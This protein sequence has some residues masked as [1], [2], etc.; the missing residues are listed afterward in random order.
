MEEEDRSD[1]SVAVE[2]DLN[3]LANDGKK[4]L[5]IEEE[6]EE[7][8]QNYNHLPPN[9]DAI[10]MKRSASVQ[11][12]TRAIRSVTPDS[13]RSTPPPR[14]LPRNEDDM[15]VKT[16]LL[17][18][19]NRLDPV[20]ARKFSYRSGV[21]EIRFELERV[22]GGIYTTQAI[23]KCR[24]ITFFAAKG[25]ETI[26]QKYNPYLNLTG[27]SESLLVDLVSG[28]FDEVFLELYNKYGNAVDPPPEIKL[29]FMVASSAVMF[30]YVN[31]LTGNL[32][33]S[34][35]TK[36]T[37]EHTDPEV[38]IDDIVEAIKRKKSGKIQEEEVVIEEVI[39]EEEEEVEVVKPTPPKKRQPRKAKAPRKEIED[40]QS[41]TLDL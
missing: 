19:L 28:N 23:N 8:H 27:W 31:T 17:F 30:H 22:K 13:H 18:E 3:L 41:L 33:P 7:D 1:H 10:S 6:D 38:N 25:L 35:N 14:N 32:Q 16:Q 40:L 21:S 36:P 11:S 20:T 37:K 12:F 34:S 15:R 26:N 2:M 39:V 29:I 5:D 24:D 9:L 4:R